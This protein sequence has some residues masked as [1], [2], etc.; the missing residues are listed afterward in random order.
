M[1]ASLLLIAF[2]AWLLLGVVWSVRAGVRDAGA[3]G[4][5]RGLGAVV[6]VV[7]ALPPEWIAVALAALVVL[8]WA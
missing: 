1:G 6:G 4:E 8:I 2:C 5:S 7:R 3:E